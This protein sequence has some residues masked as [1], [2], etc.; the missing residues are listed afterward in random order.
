MA[1]SVSQTKKIL[2]SGISALA[3]CTA[4]V[5]GGV[6]ITQPAWI[7]AAHAEGADAGGSGGNAPDGGKQGDGKQGGEAGD[8]EGGKPDSAG[9]HDAT[10]PDGTGGTGAPGEDSDGH[11]PQAGESSG[12]M[13]SKPAWAQEGIPEVELGR[14]NVARSPAQV[15]DRAYAE[16]LAS[17]SAD[18]A[19]FYS[20]SLNDAILA[21]STDFDA[22]TYIDSPLQNLALLRDALDGASVLNT[23]PSVSN[24]VDTLM[25]IF[26]GTASDKTV[27]ISPDTVTAV[28]TILG[29]PITGAAAADLAADAEAIRI[30]VLAGHG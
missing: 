18:M 30:A 27:P 12:N 9:Q 23:L 1:R 21:L 28:T 6:A 25:A 7:G 5:A 11:G 24:D 15:L 8:G 16:A 13:G 19:T 29:T 2:T 3:L 20:M 14:L 26:L 4:L 10:S 17:F 22:L